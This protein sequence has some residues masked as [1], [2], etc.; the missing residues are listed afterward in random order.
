[1]FFCSVVC[2]KDP[3]SNIVTIKNLQIVLCDVNLKPP[4][5]AVAR[6]LLNES[7]SAAS[8]ENVE[9]VRTNSG[10]KIYQ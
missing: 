1:M 3:G 5:A 7:V 6:R 9:Y 10:I 8:D 4:E 2:Y